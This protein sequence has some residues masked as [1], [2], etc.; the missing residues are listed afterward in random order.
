VEISSHVPHR[1]R[2]IR[3]VEY[4]GQRHRWRLIQNMGA[5]YSPPLPAFYLS[6]SKLFVP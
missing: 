1:R 6:F 5:D 2:P 4:R 3:P